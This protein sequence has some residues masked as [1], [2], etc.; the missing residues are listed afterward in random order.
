[1]PPSGGG[2]ETAMKTR[3]RLTAALLALT[4]VAA[5]FAVFPLEQSAE[6]SNVAK[7]KPA[8]ASR[9]GKNASKVTDGNPDT[10]WSSDRIPLYAEVDLLDNYILDKVVVKL[11]VNNTLGRSYQYAYNVYG[12]ADGVNFDRIGEMTAPEKATAEGFVFE[13]ENKTPYRVVRVMSTMSSKGSYSSTVISEIEVYGEKSDAPVIPTRETI[14]FP[15]YEE[16]LLENC[17]VDVN[18]LKDKDGKYEIKDTYTADDTIEALRGLVS[19]VL[20]DGYNDWFTFE[21]AS[22]ENGKDYYEISNDGG[23]IKIK[24]NEGV[25]VAA[26]LNHYLKYFCKVHV[27]QETRQVRMPE[28][29]VPVEETIFTECVVEV[30]YTYNY[31]TLSYTM[32]YYG[33]D[34]WQR[35]LDYL[36]LS[37]INVILDTTATEAL[38]VLYLQNFGYTLEEAKQFVCGYAWKAWWLMGNLEGYG[39]PVSDVWIKDTVEMARVNQRYMTVMGADPCLQAFTGTMPSDFAGHAGKI[40][41]SMGFDA[42]SP[43]ITSTGNWAGFLR[44]YALNTTYNGFDYLAKKFY[45]TQDYI[46]GRIGDYY[47]GDF[48]HEV[49]GNFNL[50]PKFNKANMSRTVLDKLLEENGEAVWIIQSWWE[51][52]LPEVVEGWGDDREDHILLL[53]LSAV[54]SPRWSNRTNYGGLEFGG[55]SWC[56]CILEDYGGREGVHLKLYTLAK[57]FFSALGKSK[58]MKGIG[59]TSE[60]TERNP[61]VFDLFWEMAWNPKINAK[62]W[63][64]DYAER[65]YGSGEAADAWR[66]LLDTVYG[67]NTIDGTTINDAVCNY[68]KFDYTGGYF[69][70]SYNRQECDASLK[71]L[72][73]LYDLFKNE[74][75]YVYDMVELVGTELSATATKLLGN[76]FAAAKKADYETFHIQKTKFLRAIALLDELNSFVRTQTLGNWVGRVDGFVNDARTGTYSDFDVDLMKLDA[77]ILITNWSTID[78]GNYGNRLYADLIED[79]YYRMWNAFMQAA[80]AKIKAGEKITAGDDRLGVTTTVCYNYGRE[81]GLNAV[82]G[83]NYPASPVPADGDLMHRS[84]KQVLSEIASDY[85]VDSENLASSAYLA[86][87]ATLEANDGS[88]TGT[89]K[90]KTAADI[91]AQFETTNGAKVGIL[92]GDRL[93]ADGDDYAP[94]MKLVLVESDGAIYDALEITVGEIDIDPSA[95]AE[96]EQLK[97]ALKDYAESY[98]SAYTNDLGDRARRS[99]DAYAEILLEALESDSFALVRSAYAKLDDAKA[100]FE[101]AKAELENKK[102]QLIREIVGD[103]ARIL[104]LIDSTEADPTYRCSKEEAAR[105]KEIAELGRQSFD[106]GALTLKSVYEA[107]KTVKSAEKEMRALTSSDHFVT[108]ESLLAALPFGIGEAVGYAAANAQFAV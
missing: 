42:I 41:Q 104:G 44:P 75:T 79:Y 14:E 81:V 108:A 100:L 78:L 55:S 34:E 7:D 51:N 94:G 98:A 60:G 58:H 80:E 92:D 25:S 59:L 19:R 73:D 99:L 43:N 22:S 91:S 26:G 69:Y 85:F 76:A 21:I 66:E 67:Q 56:Y 101:S 105:I 106:Q 52:P 57:N 47:A 70:P 24:G 103:Q 32:P 72:I 83:K 71:K 28:A 15:S 5:L 88:L 3:N 12:S 102:E 37:G 30:R 74:E 89:A 68:P 36:M 50:D 8:Y 62:E 9:D 39:G 49:D 95:A 46:Y 64:C 31:C 6:G 11:P 23:K 45:E 10:Y 29:V 16:W 87:G 33:F 40:M 27:S 1:M 84:L 107:A 82:F 97:T 96:K 53:D 86:N 54:Q 35:E 4:L 18:K 65:R 90:G 2:M 48:L 77:V 93:L 63:I 61:V 13:I 38:W 20:G 17:G